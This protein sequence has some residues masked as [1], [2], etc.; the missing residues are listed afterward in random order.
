[1]RGVEMELRSRAEEE[2][3]RVK[4]ELRSAQSKLDTERAELL[5]RVAKA[6]AVGQARQVEVY[7]AVRIQ[8][9][10]TRDL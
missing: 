4:A 1:M 8:G 5:Q 9:K 10:R 6:E 2:L 3:G 7:I